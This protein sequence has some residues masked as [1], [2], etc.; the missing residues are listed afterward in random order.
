MLPV[1]PLDGGRILY[2]ALLRKHRLE[3]VKIAVKAVSFCVS[4]AIF[5]L[6]IYILFATGLNM[7]VLLIGIYLLIYIFTAYDSF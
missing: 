1:I 2:F 4:V 6:G 7:S 3:V 5:L